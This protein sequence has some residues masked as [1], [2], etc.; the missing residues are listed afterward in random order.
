MGFSQMM[1]KARYF[2]KT[3]KP[4]IL[5]ITGTVGVVGG[6]IGVGVAST[7]L[8]EKVDIRRQQVEEAKAAGDMKAVRKARMGMVGDVTRLY[9]P[10][11]AVEAAGLGC[12]WLGG[13][14]LNKRNMGLTAGIAAISASYADYRARVKDEYGAEADEKFYFGRDINGNS[15][16]NPAVEAQ[17]VQFSPGST[18]RIFD[19]TNRYWNQ[20]LFEQNILFLKSKQDEMNRRLRMDTFLTLNTVYDQLGFPPTDAGL[21]YGWS[22]DNPD[23]DQYVSFGIE[24]ILAGAWR[25]WQYLDWNNGN[26]PLTFNFDKQ[27]LFGT[28][29]R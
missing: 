12:M 20:Q 25:D 9:G 19:R 18:S 1:G 26:I 21:I 24:D 8:E 22:M 10:A 27:P 17:K 4:L 23:G 7:K 11:V 6:T 16:E 15:V 28:M 14:E 3:H 13:A 2:L 29:K 5:G